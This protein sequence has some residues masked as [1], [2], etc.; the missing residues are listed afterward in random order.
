[1]HV[2]PQNV[3]GYHPL[4]ADYNHFQTLLGGGGGG[5]GL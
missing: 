4:P 2:D 5:G 3:A 1:M